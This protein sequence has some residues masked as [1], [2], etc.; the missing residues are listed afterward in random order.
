MKFDSGT[1]P[2][3]VRTRSVSSVDSTRASSG[4]RT[5]IST[6][7]SLDG[8]RI[9]S[10][11]IPRVTSCTIAPTVAT[12]APKRPAASTST[13]ISHSTPGSGRV[14]S[15]RVR[16]GVSSNRART[17]RVASCNSSQLSP[18]RR[19]LTGLP[20]AGPR[21]A[22]RISVRMPGIWSSRSCKPSRMSS[23]PGR[24][25]H[26]SR[27][28]CTWPIVSRG[29]SEPPVLLFSPPSPAKAKTSRTPSVSI[30]ICS[31]SRTCA[32]ISSTL[33]LPRAR[34]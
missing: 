13:L 27:S 8:T 25:P 22:A 28:S 10:S 2:S 20:E 31:T 17:S 3:A 26:S 4:K 14:S 5:R 29:A 32:S 33:R 9:V 7:S 12:L 16:A 18:A 19:R 1:S 30:T 23:P 24:V 6:S 21:E 15:I 11:R 34:T